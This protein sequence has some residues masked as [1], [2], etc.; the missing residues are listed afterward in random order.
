MKP[1]RRIRCEL[2]VRKF[3]DDEAL[4]KHYRSEHKRAVALVMRL[5]SALWRFLSIEDRLKLGPVTANAL[6]KMFLDDCAWARGLL[7]KTGPKERIRVKGS[8]RK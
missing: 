2:C 7:Q 1:R 4:A 6:E 5:R 3:G 8:E